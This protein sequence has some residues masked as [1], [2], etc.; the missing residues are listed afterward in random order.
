MRH[1]LEI[2]QILKINYLTSTK[3]LYQGKNIHE[4]VDD[5]LET[6]KAKGGER[7]L[8]FVDDGTLTKLGVLYETKE[9]NPPYFFSWEFIAGTYMPFMAPLIISLL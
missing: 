3:P 1:F 8:E 9:M 4:L 6:F 7:Q 2:I 5:L